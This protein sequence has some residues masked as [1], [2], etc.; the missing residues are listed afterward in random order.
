M[1]FKRLRGI[2]RAW[3][4]GGSA[5]F[6]EAVAAVS[7]FLE[8]A[9]DDRKLLLLNFVMEII[10]NDLK[11]DLLTKVLYTRRHL[12]SWGWPPF[13]LVCYDENGDRIE[14]FA[15]A[16][17]KRAVNLAEDC[18]L[19]VPW[20][21][22]RLRLTVETVG[23]DGFEFDRLNHWAYYFSPIDICYVFNGK[24][25]IA[26]GVGHKRGYIEAAEHDVS[27]IFDHVYTDGRYWYSRHSGAKLGPLY[28]FRIGILFEL[29]W[30]KSQRLS[31][32][33]G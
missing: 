18:V 30:Q 14:V 3:I 10:K 6:R 22:R 7:A 21:R 11:Y 9:S 31:G 24:H 27:V 12:S 5:E 17:K 8:G 20:D 26:A 25:S 23:T 2:G 13:P 33:P 4:P 15:D 19:V 28:D 1:F 32:C 29:A 16:G